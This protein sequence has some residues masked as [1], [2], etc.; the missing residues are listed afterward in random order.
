MYIKMATLANGQPDN[1]S[2]SSNHSNPSTNGHMNGL[3]HSPGNPSTIPMKDHD[4]IKL[5]IGQIPRNLDEK[6]LK[7]LFEEFGKIYEL[8]VL[9]DRFTGMHKGCAFLT[10]CE[11]ESALKAQSAL[12]E[13][14]TLPGM[15]RPIQVKPADSES[16]GDRKLFVGMLNKQQSE[17]DVR[18]LFEAF[19]NIEECTILRGPDGN[20]KGCAFV[21]YSSHAEAQ[22]AINALHGS[23]TMPGASSSLVVKFADTDKERT[24]R[25]MQQMAGQM[26]MF[27]PMAI[28]FGA[29]GAYAQALMQQQAAIMASVAQ[30]GYLNPMA[31]FAA[32]Q[33]QQM[34]AL[35]MNGLA[36]APMTPTSGGSTPPGITAPAVPSIP[37]PIG[38]NGFT[39]LPPQANGQPA[40]EAVFANGIHPYPGVWH[41]ISFQEA[42]TFASSK[43]CL[44]PHLCAAQSPT[45][46]DPLQQA[47]AGVQQYAGPAYPAA[48]GQISQ[49]FPQPP[50]MIPQQQREGPEG[51]NLFIYHLPQEFGDAELMQMF[52]PF[53]NVIS[54]KVFVDRATNQSK[55]FGFVSFDNPASAQAAI[56]AMNGFQIGMKRLKVQLKR[57]KDA[58]RP[59]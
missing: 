32:A 5:F 37:S 3:N 8:T 57:P 38:V 55:C 41:Q 45:A 19:G 21:K 52:L 48:Y 35:N 49:A 22:A 39:G 36:A 9:K 58:N 42:P 20:S 23:Q 54:S 28:Q 33:M 27:N 14:K 50:P 4:A 6:D 13:Q 29:Y 30:G 51:C 10:Y 53:G 15:N 56:Q 7:P 26:G 11:R 47:Y 16:R 18:R 24:M 31:A 12:H 17:D 44:Q 59:Y 40:A 25:R 34:A 2:L 1:T 46:A 43:P